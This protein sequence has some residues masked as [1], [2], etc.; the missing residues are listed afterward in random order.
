MSSILKQLFCALLYSESKTTPNVDKLQRLRHL[1][2]GVHLQASIQDTTV[3]LED[4][5]LDSGSRSEALSAF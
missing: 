4:F 1:H 3:F 2:L 5:S